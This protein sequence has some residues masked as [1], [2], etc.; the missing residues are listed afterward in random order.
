[1]PAAFAAA[2][3]L[4]EVAAA[5]PFSKMAAAF[6]AAEMAAANVVSSEDYS[7]PSAEDP[8]V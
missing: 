3:P 5:E 7:R 1:M 6:A 8:A 2:E 4:S